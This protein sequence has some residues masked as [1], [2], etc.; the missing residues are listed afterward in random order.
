MSKDIGTSRHVTCTIHV[1]VDIESDASAFLL[2]AIH[3]RA[4]SSM[5]T[6]ERKTSAYQ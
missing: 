2:D 4:R 1:N 3:I 6:V 5:D